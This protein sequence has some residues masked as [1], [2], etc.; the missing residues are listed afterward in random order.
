MVVAP[1]PDGVERPE[2][3]RDLRAVSPIYN[4][5]SMVGAA[6]AAIGATVAAVL[7]V[8]DFFTEGATGYAG[9]VLLPPVLVSLFGLAMAAWGW[10][11]ETR[12]RRRGEHSSFLVDHWVIDPLRI[13]RGTGLVLLLLGI[14]LVT[15]A[16]VAT[17]AGSMAVVEYSESN[18]FCSNACHDVMGPEATTY[19]ATAH[20]RVPCVECHVGAGAEGFLEAK[21]GGL[22]Q[23]WAVT[24]GSVQRPIPTPIHGGTISRELCERCHSPEREGG[25][26]TLTRS[27]YLN[28]LEDSAIDL[29][30]VV[31]VG[32][33]KNGLIAGGGIH[34]H[35]VVA[36]EVEFVAR[37]AQRQ[38]IAWVRVTGADGGSREYA[39]ASG[40]LTDEEKATLAPHRMECIDCHS[41]AAHAFRTPVDAVNEAIRSKRLP[42]DLYYIKR[43]GVEALDGGY[44]SESEAMSGI[45]AALRGFYESE[46][47]DVLEERAGDLAS[48]TEVLQSIYRE[49]IFP[50]MK[51]DW[52]AHPNNLGHRDSP[53]C[54]RCH[55]EDM[56]DRDG[57]AVFTDCTGCHAILAQDQG[58]I[59]TVGDLEKGM[60]FA[61]P[62][63]GQ[64][65]R[66]FKLCSKC[67]TGG[68]ELYE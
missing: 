45:E 27:Y 25:Y 36:Q 31:K 66:D 53:G 48:A 40:P 8:A 14:S 26:K 17:G 24:V 22:R 12:R 54:F 13:V 37:D 63:D 58:A 57:R 7:L 39:S 42:G 23:L 2:Q 64:F 46:D 44:P 6:I 30:M 51:A 18:A 29:A 41:R 65:I 62:Q 59:Q 49:T 68:R 19:H 43:A 32:G 10:I 67:H 1:N 11:R 38:D 52:R 15:V 35:M 33:A 47:P 28:G 56:V 9:L 21:I 20:S 61:H 50:A 3:E 4:W 34:Y 16:L 60:G 5:R 55:N